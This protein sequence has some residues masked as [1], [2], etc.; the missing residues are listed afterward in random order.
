MLLFAPHLL[1][2]GI[3]TRAVATQQREIILGMGAF[4]ELS[5]QYTFGE[6]KKKK[7]GFLM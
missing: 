6:K 4:S 1:L 5:R 7:D 2:L 3:K